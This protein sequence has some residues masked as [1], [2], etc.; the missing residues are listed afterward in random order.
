MNEFI[1]NAVITKCLL[2]FQKTLQ[3]FQLLLDMHH[4]KTHHYL[5]VSSSFIILCLTLYMLTILK[6]TVRSIP[7]KISYFLS[8]LM[9]SFL[10]ANI[11][12][13]L[14]SWLMVTLK[15]LFRYSSLL[16]NLRFLWMS[17]NLSRLGILSPPNHTA[18]M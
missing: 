18:C 9:S 2:C 8:Q 16:G 6:T 7:E 10:F 17:F 15:N 12:F 1:W 5:M 13:L 11:F 4:I 14:T 3:S